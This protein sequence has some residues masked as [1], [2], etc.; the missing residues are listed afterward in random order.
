MQVKKT[1]FGCKKEVRSTNY[2]TI[3][4]LPLQYN[5]YVQIATCILLRDK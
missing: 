1:A 5:K 3:W 4:I 2:L